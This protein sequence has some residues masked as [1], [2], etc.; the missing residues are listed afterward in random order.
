MRGK[1]GLV[2]RDGCAVWLVCHWCVVG[3]C[4]MVVP[5]VVLWVEAGGLHH[6]LRLVG[7]VVDYAVD[8]A[9]GCVV[10]GVGG[11]WGVRIRKN[12]E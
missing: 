10:G 3:W 2:C 12:K 1:S 5:S 9:V 8:G 7:G 6:G 4:A 11:L